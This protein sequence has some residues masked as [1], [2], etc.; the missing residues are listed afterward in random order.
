MNSICVLP[1][2]ALITCVAITFWL[3]IGVS[4]ALRRK[5]SNTMLPFVSVIVAVRD[6]ESTISTCLQSIISQ[7]YPREL[8]E[9]IIVD[10]HSKDDTLRLLQS[11]QKF[12]GFLLL[13]NLTSG[14]YESS[15]KTA[16]ELAIS[17]ARGE[18]LLFTDADCAPPPQWVRGM[19]SYFSPEVGLVA[20]FSP[21]TAIESCWNGFLLCDSAAAAFVAAGTIGWG[22]GITCTGRNLAYRK[23]AYDDVGGFAALPDS[24]SGDDD[25]MLQR[26]AAHPQWQIRY[27]LDPETIVPAQGPQNLRHFMRQ[28]QRHLSAGRHYSPVG[29]LGYALYHAANITLWLSAVYGL[30]EDTPYIVPLLV[31]SIIDGGALLWFLGL[32]NIRLKW[33]YIILWEP[34]FLFYHIYL[35][36]GSWCKKSSWK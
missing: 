3:G 34:F 7:N 13:R 15:K 12:A 8:L 6:G 9:I 2:A 11:L 21:Q 20:G 23:Q 33:R 16:L 19:V 24:I 35:T 30:L 18:I 26:I 29:Q 4:A 32:L 1:V 10:D 27:A 28:K 5:L 31:K 14:G 22:R 17:R 25:F 36:L